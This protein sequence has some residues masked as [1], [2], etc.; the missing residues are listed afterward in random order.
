MLGRDSVVLV[1]GGAG[2][3]GSA[4]VRRLIRETEARV[5]VLDDDVRVCR[6]FERW[7]EAPGTRPSPRPRSA[8][9]LPGTPGPVGRVHSSA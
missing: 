9:H 2:F 3:V 5:V 7:R 4:L 8:V 6:A 1:T